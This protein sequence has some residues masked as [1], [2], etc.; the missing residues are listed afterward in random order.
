MMDETPGPMDSCR[1]KPAKWPGMVYCLAPS[2]AHCKFVRHFSKSAYCVHPDR[3]AIIAQT[4]A[5]EVAH[6]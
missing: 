1:A 6:K 4:R 5:G 2:S 3:E